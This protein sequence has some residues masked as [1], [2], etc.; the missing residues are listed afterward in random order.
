MFMARA[1]EAGSAGRTWGR[2]RSTRTCRRAMQKPSGLRRGGQLD[3]VSGLVFRST[4]GV[5]RWTFGVTKQRETTPRSRTT[6]VKR[7][8]NSFVLK[9]TRFNEVF[10]RCLVTPNAQRPTP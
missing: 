6:E 4:L 9:F 2:T 8:F 10:R 1:P 3:A 5:G 7:I